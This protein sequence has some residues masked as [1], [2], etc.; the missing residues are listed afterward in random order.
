MK[1]LIILFALIII[2]CS[3]NK[4]IQPINISGDI[5]YVDYQLN[6][7]YFEQGGDPLQF[8]NNK[9][10]IEYV[11]EVTAKSSSVLGYQSDLDWLIRQG[12]IS[13]EVYPTLNT[14]CNKIADNGELLLIYN[15]PNW[16]ID[17]K[18]DTT[19]Q[20]GYFYLNDTLDLECGNHTYLKWYGVD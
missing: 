5:M 9:E 3:T 14:M 18:R 11:D 2:S 6:Q 13:I 1:Y 10:M 16:T 20:I 15:G 4:I 7:I 19:Y 12:Y 8:K 17:A